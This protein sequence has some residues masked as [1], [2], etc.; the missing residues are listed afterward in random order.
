V[1][2]KTLNALAMLIEAFILTIRID[3]AMGEAGRQGGPDGIGLAE[4]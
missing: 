2:G 4:E 3:N 1:L